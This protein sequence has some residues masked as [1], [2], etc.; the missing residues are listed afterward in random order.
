MVFEER[1]ILSKEDFGDIVRNE[2]L[3]R[4]RFAAQFVGGKKVLDIAC[5][6]GYGSKFLAESGASEV[7]GFDCDAEIVAENQKNNSL[8]NLIYKEGS[9]IDIPV[10]EKEFDIAVSFETIEHLKA[11]DQEK[12]VSELKRAVSD[13]GLVLISTPN[14]VISNN[15]NPY[16]I[17]ELDREDFESILKKYFSA[18]IVFE[19]GNGI[20][21]FVKNPISNIIK[22]AEIVSFSEPLYFLAVVPSG[23]FPRRS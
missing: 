12:F 3:A 8:K 22:E 7:V 18:V 16:H 17:K 1:L 5:G 23:K 2:H 6:S 14:L 19:Q 13:E 4:Y 9:A 10:G 21:S 11:E 15:K 20:A